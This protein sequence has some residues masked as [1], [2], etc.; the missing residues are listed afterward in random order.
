LPTFEAKRKW[1]PG[2]L[3]VLKVDEWARAQRERSLIEL[4][5][6]TYDGQRGPHTHAHT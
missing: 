6:Y 1:T 2:S 5:M 3:N 4:Y